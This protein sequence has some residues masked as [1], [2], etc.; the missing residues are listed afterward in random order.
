MTDAG[1]AESIRRGMADCSPAERKVA[2]VLLSA[3]PSAGFETVARLAERA[4]VSGPTVLRFVH[5]LGYRGFP[6]FQ[7]ALRHDLDE[8]SASP[9]RILA[10]RPPIDGEPQTLRDRAAAITAGTVQRTFAEVSTHDLERC[11]ELISQASGSVVIAGGRYSNLLGR[12]L[13]L[14]LE[15]LRPRVRMLADQPSARA[16]MV[17]DLGRR[18]VVVLFDYRRYEEPTL[19][20]ARLAR[21]RHAALVLF[22]DTFLSPIASEAEVVLAS[23]TAAPSPFDALTPALA[24]IETVV[25]GCFERLGDAAVD[26]MARADRAAA[27]LGL[28]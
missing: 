9:L 17:E 22:T 24:L 7:E 27:D 25:A 20:L 28:Y 5:R 19:R 13:S 6:D 12:V 14:H 2:R 15:Q 23:E 11:V 8:R 1:V 3:Y 21:E 4:G 26:R 16:A 18:D 10:S